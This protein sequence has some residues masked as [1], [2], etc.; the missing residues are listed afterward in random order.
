VTG[1]TGPSGPSGPTGAG[2]TGPTGATGTTGATGPTGT[3]GVTAYIVGGAAQDIKR[4]N[5][6]FFSL[7][8]PPNGT[9]DASEPQVQQVVTADGT[10]S[11]FNVRLSAAA[12]GAGTSYTFN[13]RKNGVNTGVGCIITGAATSCSDTVNTASFSTNDLISVSAVP[14]ANPTP[15]QPTDNLEVRWTA[16]MAP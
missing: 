14:S 3:N 6:T 11:Q 15:G 10:L 2:A 8:N 9:A 4:A 7:F 5:T 1:P 16:R 12:G 13:V